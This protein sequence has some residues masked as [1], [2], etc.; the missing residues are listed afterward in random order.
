MGLRGGGRGSAYSTCGRR[1]AGRGAARR[2][3][4]GSYAGECA[5]TRTQRVAGGSARAHAPRERARRSA[6][7][8]CMGCHPSSCTCRSPG[9]ACAARRR[10][11]TRRGAAARRRG[12]RGCGRVG[13]AGVRGVCVSAPARARGRVRAVCEGIWLRGGGCLGCRRLRQGRAAWGGSGRGGVGAACGAR[14][15]ARQRGAGAVRTCQA[16]DHHDGETP[17]HCDACLPLQM[18]ARVRGLGGC[19]CLGGSVRWLVRPAAQRPGGA[20]DPASVGP[21]ARQEATRECCSRDGGGS[22]WQGT[23]GRQISVP[24]CLRKAGPGLPG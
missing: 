2:A 15:C 13:G 7:G 22:R 1:A 24:R 23:P 5:F 21:A 11:A 19:G 20:G 9:A 18:R 3:A 16:G 6:A 14:D 4:A 17:S 12:L 10:R 8:C